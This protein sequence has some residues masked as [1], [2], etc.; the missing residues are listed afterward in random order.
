MRKKLVLIGAG[1]AMF[2]Q[3]LVM[4][5]IEQ[6]KVDKWHLSLVDID[7]KALEPMR[8]LCG[9][10]ISEKGADIEL[11]YSTD[12]RDV[13]EGAD[14][15]VSTIG[16]GGRRAWEQ[17]VFIPRK[18]G[19]FQPVGDSVAPGGI[20]RAMRMIP[21]MV[22]ITNDIIKLCPKARFFNYSNPMT[23]ICRAVRKNTGFP[24]I[25][26]CHGVKN[27]QRRIARFA[28]LDPAK[29]SSCAA[30][31]NHMVF[32][33]DLRF[34]GKDA[35]PYIFD[36]LRTKETRLGNTEEL[37]PLSRN[38]IE[39]YRAYPASD[40]RHF[41]EFTQENM[42]KGNYFGKTLGMDAYS[43]ERTIE[44]GDRIYAQTQTLAFSD[45]PLADEFFRRFE[46]E[47]EQ[48]MEIFDSIEHDRKKIYSVNMPNN[49]AIPGLP[50]DAVLELPAA[51]AASGFKQLHIE[52]FPQLLKGIIAKH[53]AI[54]EIT[55]E[56]ALK[57]DRRLF[58]EAVMLGGYMT[59]KNAASMM[60]DELIE[61]QK[62]F[63][64]QF[65]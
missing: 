53:V 9:K 62:Q 28:G 63:L 32:I 11:S 4:D 38:F 57:G 26:L 6:A 17:D 39:T 10:M 40:D 64:P 25:G 12:R 65:K 54:G 45:K 29:V 2:T 46:G 31:V 49:G 24:V 19:V 23:T 35:W 55:V 56:A 34:D 47:H 61:T 16:V 15:V 3:G 8:L 41:S 50:E 60:V 22:D 20:S 33:Y 48:L 30:G 58:L 43:F 42:S 5:L 51:A 59:D 1:S 44:E 18:Y 21:A 7:P 27:G 14:Y 37:G 13:L 52:D 36:K